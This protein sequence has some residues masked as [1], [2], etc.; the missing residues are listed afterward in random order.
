MYNTRK[1]AYQL[2]Y[3]NGHGLACHNVPA[4]GSPICPS[5]DWVGLG[6]TVTTLNIR[7]Y[8]VLLCHAAEQAS[9]SPEIAE[10]FATHKNSD[11]L[12]E[13]YDQGVADAIDADVA[14]T[15]YEHEAAY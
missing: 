13:A 7:D 1:D 4:L 11:K 14:A 2:G 8:H 15:T 12:Q 5:V 6:H 9:R 3:N 10:I